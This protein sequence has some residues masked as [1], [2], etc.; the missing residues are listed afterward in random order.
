MLAKKPLL[1]YVPD[2][3]SYSAD[4]GLNIDPEERFPEISYRDAL[5]MMETIRNRSYDKA[6]EQRVSDVLV[7]SCD[8]HSTRR[9]V[10]MVE[11]ALEGK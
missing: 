4:C 2:K 9:I 10:D 5:E 3:E 8:G 6:A 11:A 7:G 1:F